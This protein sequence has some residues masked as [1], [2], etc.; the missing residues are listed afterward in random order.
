MNDDPVAKVMAISEKALAKNTNKEVMLPSWPDSRRGTPNTFLRSALFSAIQSKDRV[1]MKNV[2]L[3]SQAGIIVTYTG[4]QLNQEDLSVWEC[5]VHLAKESPLGATCEFTSYEILKTLG[6]QDAGEN[7]KNLH[8]IIIRLTAC[9]VQ[10]Q[11]VGQTFFGSLISSGIRNDETGRYS[12]TLSKDL[13][14]LYGKTEWTSVNW[15][16]RK[17]LKRKPLALS[18]HSYYSSHAKP[19]AISLTWLKN[20]VAGSKNKQKA[21]FKAKVEKSLDEL[22]KVGFLDSWA[23]NGELILVIRKKSP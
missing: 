12:I 9:A 15:E 10:I 1:D 6:I 3:G 11:H 18:L 2:I 23:I 5:L 21:G 19:F 13:L 16:Q 8:D 7:Y 17:S 20:N 22:V 4:E 14:K